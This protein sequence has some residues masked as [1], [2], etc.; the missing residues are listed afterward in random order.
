MIEFQAHKKWIGLLALAALIGLGNAPLLSIAL[1]KAEHK[2]ASLQRQKKQALAD[3]RQ[4]KDD[5]MAAQNMKSEIDAA[6]AQKDL[7][8]ID[9]LR[10]A[11]TLEERAEEALFSNLSY[12]FSPEEKAEFDTVGAGKQRLAKSKWNVKADVPSDTDAYAFL[13]T[14]ARTLPGRL[15]VLQ[16]SLERINARETSN[17]NLRFAA[18]G[19]W[20]SNGASANPAEKRP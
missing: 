20:L 6:E 13:D 2:R 19:E 14:L 9:R 17:A 18:S 10:A 5:I 11:R 16:L 8:P 7:A 4:L 12:A 15:T 1:E 3:L